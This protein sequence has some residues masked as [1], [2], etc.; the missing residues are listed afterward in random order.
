MQRIFE[1][2][3]NTYPHMLNIQELFEIPVYGSWIERIKKDLSPEEYSKLTTYDQIEELTINSCTHSSMVENLP[4]LPGEFPFTR[5]FNRTDNA[6]KVGAY[7]HVTDEC[8]SNEKALSLLMKGSDLLLFDLQ[9]EEIDLVKLLRDIGLDYI[10]SQ[11]KLS[12]INQWR[13]LTDY[14]SYE[15]PSTI[16][17][18]LDPIHLTESDIEEVA[19]SLKSKQYPVFSIEGHSILETGASSFQEI[20]FDLSVGHLILFKLMKNGLT[21]DEAAACI[22]F[23]PGIGSNYFVEIAKLRALRTLWAN[24]VEAYHPKHA[25]SYN[26]MITAHTIGL[27]KSLKDPHTNLLRQTTEGMSAISGGA[28][29]LIIYPYDSMSVSSASHL[30]ERMALNISLLLKEE[31]HFDTVNDPLGGSYSV[32]L[33]TKGLCDNAWL[34][35]KELENLGGIGHPEAQQYLREKV[36]QKRVL[37]TERFKSGENV[38]IGINKFQ[39]P[40]PQEVCFKPPSSY[41][42]IE[43][44]IIERDVNMHK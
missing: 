38:L 14:F 25:C 6:W 1:A 10:E 34:L 36:N 8:A 41:L 35:F 22:H 4:K 23:S 7:I 11:F 37:R 9:K 13:R 18:N 28:N 26:C 29:G 44:L 30:A 17:F 27:N 5:G 19:R 42:G 16:K 20:A 33:L 24:V 43:M 12:N 40:L 32:E 21:I 3:N 39:N 2:Q 15:I 31:S